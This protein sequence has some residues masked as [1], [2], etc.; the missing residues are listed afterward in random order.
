M[1]NIFLKLG[2]LSL[3]F[4]ASFNNAPAQS[5]E[6]GKDAAGILRETMKAI[7]NLTAVE[8]DVQVN[9]ERPL[10]SYKGVKVLAKT[11]IIAVGSPLRAVARLESLDGA[12]YEAFTQNDKIM[13]YSAAGKIGINDLSKS[14]KPLTALADLNQTWQLL[15]NQEF[16]AKIIEA[17]R[18]VYGG[19]EKIGDDL[20]DVVVQVSSND[21]EKSISTNY[22][23]ISSQTKLPRA[24]QVVS[25][26]SQGSILQPRRVITIIKQNPP[27]TPATFAY[28]PKEKDSVAPPAPAAKTNEAKSVV[29]RELT[30]WNGKPLPAL[31]A[32]DISLKKINFADV[33]DKPTL[34]TFWATWCGPC[35]KEMPSF[36]KMVEK[37]KGKFQVL[38]VGVMDVDRPATLEF[39]K[40]HPEYK[41]TFL[42]DPY[43]EQEN[44]PIRTAL[45]INA[46]P[47]NLLVDANGKIVSAWRGERKE[48]E[49]TELVDKLVAK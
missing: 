46:L 36:Q 4:I 5:K 3:I 25:M 18:I 44:S 43:W 6:I 12:T 47:T 11:K 28:T 34:I 9:E 8:Y 19:Q 41:F 24:R 17:G 21:R 22:Y 48:A 26:Y 38:A 42:L 33:I 29:D 16:Y 40:K 32:D 2:L 20:C 10:F 27:I 1:K 39:I 31:I 30:E 45:G 37:Y 14:F 15:L 35:L 7:G 49:W 13:Q 23:W